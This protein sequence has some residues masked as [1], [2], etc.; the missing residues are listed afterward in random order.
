MLD[1]F[2]LVLGGAALE[3][4]GALLGPA[5]DATLT[6]RDFPAVLLQPLYRALPAL[7]VG[8]RDQGI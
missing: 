6:V 8:D 4:K 3:A 7:Q 2:G 1:E 5:Q